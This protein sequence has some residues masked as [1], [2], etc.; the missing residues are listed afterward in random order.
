MSMTESTSSLDL[1]KTKA[2]KLF[3]GKQFFAYCVPAIVLVYFVYV[4]FAF[5]IMGLAKRASWDNAVTL[6]SDSWSYKVHVTRENRTGEVEYSVEGERK[7]AYPEGQRPDWVSRDDIV[8]VALG[9]GHIVR[10]L[11]DNVTHFE[12]PGYGVIE[13]QAEGR[14]VTT[15]LEDTPPEWINASN[16][17]VAITTVA[18]R[19]TITGTKTEV[20]NYFPGWEL[21]WFTFDSP[22]HGASLGQILFGD[23]IDPARGNIPGA[24]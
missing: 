4:F 8:V 15:N 14:Q 11:P 23:R 12:I 5:D 1:A 7:G 21:F 19:V 2:D 10:L 13:A 22:Y 18:G 24:V 17:R 20:F 6:A 16:R 9:E 3:R